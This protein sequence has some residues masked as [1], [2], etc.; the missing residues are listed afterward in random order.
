M[1]FR[2]EN[3]NFNQIY[4]IFHYANIAFLRPAQVNRSQWFLFLMYQRIVVTGNRM[5]TSVIPGTAEVYRFD[6]V[7][8]LS[9]DRVRALPL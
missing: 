8:S 2:N 5:V 9:Y 1:G 4:Q 3:I 7:F 6:Q